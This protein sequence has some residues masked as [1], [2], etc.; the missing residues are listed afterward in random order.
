MFCEFKHSFRSLVDLTRTLD[1]SR[2]VTIVLNADVSQDVTGDLLDVICVNR[3]YGWYSDHGYTES[4]NGSL[5]SDILSWRQ[6]YRRPTILSEY[7]ADTIEG[8][9]TEPSTSF[10]VQYQVELLARTQEAIDF[11]KKRKDLA[12]EMIWNFADFMTAQCKFYLNKKYSYLRYQSLF[13]DKTDKIIFP[14]LTR[15][16][17]NHKGVLTRNRQP[18]M[19]AYLIK[20]RYGRIVG[21]S[22]RIP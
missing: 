13:K 3:Y 17:G 4:I 8:M 15:V 19:A 12:G 9:S 18:K 11:L 1:K 21:E 22:K 2:P 6:K 14:A 16:I 10:S 5:T 7:G 20:Q